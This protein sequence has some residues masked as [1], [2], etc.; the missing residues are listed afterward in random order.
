MRK[1]PCWADQDVNRLARRT[2][3]HAKCMKVRLWQEEAIVQT[4]SSW[5]DKLVRPFDHLRVSSKTKD[6]VNSDSTCTCS[7]LLRTT[8]SSWL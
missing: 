6:T 1:N 2:H 3:A 4:A 8:M 5:D 7:Y